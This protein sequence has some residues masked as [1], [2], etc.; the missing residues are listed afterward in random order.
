MDKIGN[1]EQNYQDNE[2][3]RLMTKSLYDKSEASNKYIYRLYQRIICFLLLIFVCL[4]LFYLSFPIYFIKN[5]PVHNSFVNNNTITKEELKNI[6]KEELKNIIKEEF[7]NTKKEVLNENLNNQE[8]NNINKKYSENVNNREILKKDESKKNLE[9]LK[10]TTFQNITAENSHKDYIIE[11]KKIRVG[12]I[13]VDN[14]QNPGNNLLKYAMSTKLKEYGFDPIIIARNKKNNRIDFLLKTVNL[15]IVKSSFH[16]LKREDYD[17]LMINSD[18]CWTYSNKL[19]F[20]DNAF[21]K[22]AQYWNVTKFIYAA[23]MGTMRWFF[24]KRDD[25]MAKE[26]LKDFK[27]ISFREIGT[28]KMAEEHLG[29]NST[30]VL[31]PTLLIDKSYY[32]DL[33]KNYKR[34]FDF[35]KK[36]IMIFQLD[37]NKMIKKFINKAAKILNFTIYKVSHQDEYYVENFI[38]AMNISQAVITDSYHGTI[39]SI[40]FNRPFISFVNERRGAQRFISLKNTFNLNNRIINQTNSEANISLLIEPLNI[41]QTKLN[42]LKNISINFLKKNLGLIN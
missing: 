8:F 39:F 40:I 22:F 29:I 11:S 1:S 15:K 26:L 13:G 4:F 30:F 19:Y 41:N 21:L 10:D 3:R 36:Y 33:I 2:V 20:Y 16:E 17:I 37:E 23:S 38:F 28:A 32:L 31:D 24:S 9:N 18:L 25:I 5:Y 42:E 35:N 27:G 6:I 34:E 14:D 7:N 12:V